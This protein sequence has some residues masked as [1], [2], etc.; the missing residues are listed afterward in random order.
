MIACYW[1]TAGRF[2]R[3]RDITDFRCHTW[4]GGA[5]SHHGAKAIQALY[6]LCRRPFFGKVCISDTPRQ[7]EEQAANSAL[8]CSPGGAFSP[9]AVFSVGNWPPRVCSAALDCFIVPHSLAEWKGRC[10]T[11]PAVPLLSS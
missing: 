2:G 1:L 9:S 3:V 6:F 4:H 5:I 11:G 7:M 8:S 10:S